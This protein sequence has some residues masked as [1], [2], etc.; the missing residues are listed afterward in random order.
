MKTL[1]SALVTAT[2][3]LTAVEAGADGAPGE[4]QVALKIEA[5]TLADA[6]DE[7][8]RQSGYQIFVQNWEV[9]KK[10][11]APRL[12]G[13][14]S[15]RD[16]LDRL[17]E[18]TQF[19]SVWSEKA[20]TIREKSS[21]IA[22]Q[23]DS[24]EAPQV[25]KFVSDGLEARDAHPEPGYSTGVPAQLVPLD[26]PRKD[27]LEE[28]V[29]TGTHIRG[30]SPR[31]SPLTVYDRK[32]IDQ[33]GAATVAQ[34]AR[35][36][37]QNFSGADLVANSSSNAVGGRFDQGASDNLFNGAAFNLHG[38]GTTSTLTLLNGHRLAPAGS[39]GLLT[40]V[41]NIPLSAVERIDVLTDGASAIYGADAVAGVVNILTRQDFDGGETSLRYGAASD[42]GGTEL[43]ASQVL[44]N[45]WDTGSGLVTYEYDKQNG[46]DASARSYIPDQGG[47]SSLIPETTRHSV[48]VTAHQDLGERLVLSGDA[49]YSKRDFV[50]DLSVSSLVVNRRATSTGNAD[51]SGVSLTLR[52]ELASDWQAQAAGSYSSV[53]QHQQ[54]HQQTAFGPF[55]FDSTNTD[56][57]R[58]R[59]SM[60]EVLFNGPLAR[61]SS[62]NL[63][64]AV[65]ATYRKEQFDADTDLTQFGVT[66]H[67]GPPGLDR[68]V[69][70]AFAEILL[71]IVGPSN[72]A[73]AARKIEL[74]AAV[75]YDDYDDFGSS[76]NPKVGILWEPI[77]G[78][79]LRATYGTSFRAPPLSQIGGGQFSQAVP[80]ANPNVPAGFTNTIYVSG[81]NPALQPEEARSVTAGIDIKPRS[82]PRL[83]LGV[84]Y[85]RTHFDSR[86]QAPLTIGSPNF[87]DPTLAPFIVL[88]PPLADV[89]RYFNSPGFQGDSTGAGPGGIEAIF[90]NKV[91]NIAVTKQSG[92]DLNGSYTIDGD[93][94]DL[95]FSAV[96]TRLL[97]NDYQT[98]SLAPA[99]S[100]IDTFAE[101]TTWK[102]RGGVEWDFANWSASVMA[103]YVNGYDNTPFVP[104]ASIS[105]WTTADLYLSYRMQRQAA[106]SPALTI[107]LTVQNALNERPPFVATPQALLLP[108]QNAIPYDPSN[109][110][111]VGRLIALQVVTRW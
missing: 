111:P 29:V 66:T 76:T 80:L 33:S 86:I 68:H 12:R 94:H 104:R 56:E 100:L 3:A 74:S 53:D 43:S 81:G 9:T 91:A 6:L 51:L 36:I 67:F 73:A 64:A 52:A 24:A 19:I 97:S 87:S 22:W 17:L 62:G 59:T 57:T 8:A 105:S 44:G 40:D 7:W 49:I 23:A 96:A 34:F 90:D 65:G 58:N 16:A 110:S 21:P 89:Q 83:T 103:N 14:Y 85:F 48:F 71:P 30:A 18:G 54:A 50:R 15:A 25:Q 46:L 109:A 26:A 93:E 35:K 108:G 63:T 38:L 47:P 41:S 1:L 42:G 45:V 106:A 79:D 99:V 28:V 61:L 88:N 75:R 2:L 55:S 11:A 78:V 39:N 32:K 107:A 102:A 70:S 31:S 13:K 101:P 37:V 60:F 10:I 92:I 77:A 69:S 72:T 84:T 98:T 95:V 4:R 5:K 27:Q 20:V 82:L